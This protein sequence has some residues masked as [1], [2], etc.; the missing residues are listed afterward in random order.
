M[1]VGYRAHA[2]TDKHFEQGR[3]RARREEKAIGR[4]YVRSQ[5]HDT[6]MPL[7]TANGNVVLRRYPT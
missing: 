3:S 4:L 7:C 2:H 1:A 5:L 6:S